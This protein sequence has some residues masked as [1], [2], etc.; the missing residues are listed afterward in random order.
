MWRKLSL[1]LL[2]GVVHFTNADDADGIFRLFLEAKPRFPQIKPPEIL[3][4]EDVRGV[5]VEVLNATS[6]FNPTPACSV[7]RT[8]LR[9]GDFGIILTPNYPRSYPSNQAC[10]WY[11]ETEPGT[12][13]ETT[14]FDLYTQPWFFTYFDYVQFTT[15]GN[16]TNAERMTGDLN[17]RTPF[18]I[19]SKDNKMG[20]RFRSS[21]LFNFRGLK[22]QYLV[23]PTDP[24]KAQENFVTPFDGV[25]GQSEILAT[26][27]SSTQRPSL[28]G[29][30]PEY[31]IVG[32]QQPSPVS[33]TENPYSYLLGDTT[34]RTGPLYLPPFVP[35]RPGQIGSVAEGQRFTQ[36]HR[37]IGP[38]ES[39]SGAFPW[40]AALLIDG[41][42]FCGGSL[43]DNV[44]ILT[45]AHCTDGAEKIVAVVGTNSLKD[46]EPGRKIYNITRDG[47][48]QHPNYNGNNIAF[49]VAIL[50]LPERVQF[51][52][53]IRPICLPNR[54]YSSDTFRQKVVRVSGWGKPGDESPSISYQLKNVTVA[55][56]GNGHCRHVFRGIVTGNNIC[57]ASKTTVSPCRGDSGGPLVIRQSAPDGTPFYMQVGIVSFGGTSCE[58]ALPVGY[59]RVTA[60]FDY[61]S[62]VTGRLF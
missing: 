35:I 3:I 10:Q 12:R 20:I 15:D 59:S 11:L 41:K 52:D 61:I 1:V 45:A 54:F 32:P 22:L 2:I 43:I 58:Q 56:M 46:P 37:I 30:L 18:T 14:V 26:E 21:A 40:M 44:H 55:V 24:Q 47:I 9:A 36:D 6:N 13:I 8:D 51:T 38:G 39:P 29:I 33:P 62:T 23:R 4:P 42:Q 5:K 7:N 27:D 31:P 25:C 28:P 16:F 48:F 53:K 17:S 19:V 57:T 49:D 34:P 60:F 50:R